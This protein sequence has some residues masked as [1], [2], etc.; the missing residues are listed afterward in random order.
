[1]AGR[2]TCRLVALGLALW[3][4]S[5]SGWAAGELSGRELAHSQEKGNCLA[6]HR[7]PADPGAETHA[8]MGPIL[9]DIQRRYPDRSELRA[10]IWDARRFN[11]DT[12]MPPYGRHRIL[13][14][15]EID[16]VVDYVSGL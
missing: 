12:I 8:T 1:M 3:V 6:C 14:E 13:T 11:P 7:M 4:S 16:R 5:A 9:R 15:D 2:N 10:R